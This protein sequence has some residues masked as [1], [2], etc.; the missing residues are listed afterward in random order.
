MVK[1]LIPPVQRYRII[2]KIQ[3]LTR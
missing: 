2:T 1:Q 3:Q